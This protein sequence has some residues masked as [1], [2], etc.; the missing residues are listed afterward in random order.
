MRLLH[1][2]F[3]NGTIELPATSDVVWL[4]SCDDIDVPTGEI[5][6]G[7]QIF[8]LLENDVNALSLS[9]IIFSCIDKPINAFFLSISISNIGFGAD[10]PLPMRFFLPD[11]RDDFDRMCF[12]RFGLR[13]DD[14]DDDELDELLES[15]LLL[16][17]E[18]ELRL[19]ERFFLR[20]R[21]DLR[22]LPELLLL[23]LFDSLESESE[24]SESLL[25]LLLPELELG[26]GCLL[27][28]VL[29]ISSN[30]SFL[31]LMLLA[32]LFKMLR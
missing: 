23:E 14:D 2:N 28:I 7:L 20:C 27:H 13:L 5:N 6:G 19:W 17:S 16:L 24:L 25:L 8:S 31:C 29:R 3:T 9:R 26:N 4:I 30:F 12:D 21:R 15:E 22:T 11:F 1:C 10:R 18:S 32:N